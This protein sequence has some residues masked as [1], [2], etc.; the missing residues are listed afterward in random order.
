MRL[1]RMRS[2]VGSM[3]AWP[4][5]RWVVAVAAA[6]LVGLLIGV[7][8]GV[9]RTS[10]YTRMTPVTWWDYP[11]W[12]ISALLVGLTAATYVRVGGA[13]SMGADR[14][15]R[16]LGATLLSTFAVGCPICNKLVVALIGVSGALSYWAPLQPVLGVLG[17]MLLLG[18]LTVRLGG[19]VAYPTADG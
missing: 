14:S 2:A 11:V 1:A 7:P 16:A 13:A 8:T 4:P 15:R 10:F 12:A 19:Q 9:V 18:G 5:R 3:R 6:V 17:I